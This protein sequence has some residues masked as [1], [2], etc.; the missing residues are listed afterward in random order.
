MRWEVK[1]RKD[2]FLAKKRYLYSSLFAPDN[3][4]GFFGSCLAMVLSHVGYADFI[5][6][7]LGRAPASGP[8]RKE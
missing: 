2:F 6:K 7:T 4:S 3:S 5:G 1:E 8:Y